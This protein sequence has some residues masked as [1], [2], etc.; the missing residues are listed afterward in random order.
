MVRLSGEDARRNESVDRGD[1][2]FQQLGV[3]PPLWR[4]VKR[5]C[6]AETLRTFARALIIFPQDV[7][8]T[9]QPVFVGG[10]QLDEIAI[11]GLK[12]QDLGT[13]HGNV[14]VVDDVKFLAKENFQYGVR[15]W[16]GSAGLLGDQ[17]R[18]QAPGTPQA[19]YRY[20]GMIRKRRC[21]GLT[22]GENAVT[23]HAVNDVHFVAA[24]SKGI[25]Q[26]M[27]I[28]GVPAETVRRIKT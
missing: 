14:V 19:M 5:Q 13:E 3:S 23:V 27:E 9:N 2:A 25:G 21:A 4:P 20:I 7:H 22:P 11:I 16:P 6:A 17:R 24:T 26:A 10:V 1:A 12:P 8:G 28:Y 18:E 15:F